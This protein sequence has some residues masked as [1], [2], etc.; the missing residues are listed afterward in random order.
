MVHWAAPG[1]ML[2]EPP[3]FP[4]RRDLDATRIYYLPAAPSAEKSLLDEGGG[5]DTGANRDRG[6]G[7][8]SREAM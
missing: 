1:M 3:P 7:S 4:G 6:K 5:L 2:P 8:L